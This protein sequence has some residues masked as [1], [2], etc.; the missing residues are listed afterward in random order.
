MAWRFHEHI[1]RGELD[2]TVRGRVTGRIWLAAV[3]EPLVFELAGDCAPDLAGCAITFENPAPVAMTTRPPAAQQRGV[4]GEITAAR[5]VRVFDVPLEKAFEILDAGGE[6]PA[7]LANALVIEWFN[8]R[9]GVFRF[10]TTEFRLTVSPAAWRFT[11]A[12]IAERGRRIAEETTEFHL[13]VREDGEN[14]EWDEFRNEQ[15]LRESDTMNQRCRRLHDQ[16]GHEDLGERNLAH[17]MGWETIEEYLAEKMRTGRDPLAGGGEDESEDGG[18]KNESEEGGV[19]FPDDITDYEDPE[20]DPAREGIDWVRDDEERIVHPIYKTGRDL[21]SEAMDELKVPARL[22]TEGEDESAG[23]FVG[24]L[25]TLS[26]KLAG[27]LGG[28]ARDG[29]VP[30]PTFTVATLKRVLEYHNA[31]LTALAALDSSPIL[32]AARVAHYRARLFA[33]REDIIALITRLRGES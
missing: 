26:A 27:A 17:I 33:I 6:P 18:G 32:G 14:G 2:N 25:M 30:D 19:F 11:A 23:E 9:C 13:A 12:E 21:C 20:P 31:A 8:P 24:Q 4:T 15:L 16:Y 10:E 1:V 5:K 3:V 29:D 22:F 7:H 28:L